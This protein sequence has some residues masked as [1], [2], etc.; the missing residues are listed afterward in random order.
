MEEKEV[1]NEWSQYGP[2]T[3]TETGSEV[4]DGEHDLDRIIAD[5]GEELD[6]NI[7]AV[8]GYGAF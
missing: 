4:S 1:R 7:W 6:D 2:R 3:V 8:E 5:D